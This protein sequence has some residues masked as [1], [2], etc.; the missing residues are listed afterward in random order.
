MLKNKKPNSFMV[1]FRSVLLMLS[2]LPL[3][4]SAEA[5]QLRPAI[6]NLEFTQNG[7]VKVHIQ[8]N[9][10]SLIAGIGSNHDDTDDSPQAERY[11]QLRAL[12]SKQLSSEFELVAEA[13]ISQ[14]NLAFD[15][16]K[17]DLSFVKLG[18]PEI[19]NLNNS[20]LSDL[21]L[22]ALIPPA[23]QQTDQSVNQYV[24]WQYP[25]HFGN[26]IAHFFYDKTP[27]EKTSHWLTKGATSP[28]FELN[29]AYVAKPFS[30][31]AVE[32]TIL[33]F[34]HIV[35]KGTDHILFVL[36]LFLLSVRLRP[37]LLQ[38]TAFTLAHSITLGLTIYGAISLSPSVIEPLIALSIVAVGVENI[39][40]KELK[41]RRVVI[42]FLF[43]LLHGM[44]FAG[45]LSGLGLPESD[46]LTALIFFNLGVEAGQLAVIATA[47]LLVFWL[48]KNP[49][50]YRQW[51]VIPTSILISLIGIL[52][53]YERV[54]L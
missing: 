32:Y 42:V 23:K 41:T 21:Y 39:F 22:L 38:I 20:R 37:L 51:V 10:E 35:P 48:L 19:G 24:T 29:T 53:T 13:T 7:L 33:G 47:F 50:R 43:G 3:M 17:S 44:G 15:S 12:S 45:V 31:V 25:Q 16:I 28:K 54:F 40:V 1:F 49:Q 5:H 9:L 8:T 14:F 30:Q 6:V 26:N 4:Q 36:G 52:W 34:E 27:L 46:F 2:L 11:N 18:I